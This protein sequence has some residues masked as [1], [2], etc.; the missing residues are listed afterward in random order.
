[1]KYVSTIIYHPRI[2]TDVKI[3]TSRQDSLQISVHVVRIWLVF[4]LTTRRLGFCP[5]YTFY[6]LEPESRSS[7]LGVL[8]TRKPNQNIE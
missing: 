1:M 2:K 5:V 3:L 6:G 4:T 8:S 7:Q